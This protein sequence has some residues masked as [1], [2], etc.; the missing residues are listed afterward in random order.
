MPYVVAT[1]LFPLGFSPHLHSFQIRFSWEYFP[2]MPVCRLAVLPISIL[3]IV[4]VFGDR[5]PDRTI[6]RQLIQARRSV[7]RPALSAHLEREQA[8]RGLHPY[9]V[10][11]P[12]LLRVLCVSALSLSPSVLLSAN[13]LHVPLSIIGFAVPL[14][15]STSTPFY[16]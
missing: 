15:V 12:L 14:S 4:A 11:V 10:V 16:L 2:I 3:G 6:M 1:H 13:V 8:G 5:L 9:A 7:N